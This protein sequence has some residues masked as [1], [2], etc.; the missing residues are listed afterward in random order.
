MKWTDRQIELAASM[1]GHYSDYSDLPKAIELISQTLGRRVSDDSLYKAFMRRDMLPLSKWFRG[2]S[3]EKSL[4]KEWAKFAEPNKHIGSELQS[5]LDEDGETNAVQKLLIL[6]DIHDPFSDTKAVDLAVKVGKKRGTDV[7]IQL[8]D[9]MDCLSVSPYRDGE[10]K[11]DLLDEIDSANRLLDKLDSIGAKRKILT[12]GNHCAR[13]KKYLYNNAP[14]VARMID[15]KKELRLAERGWEAID[16]G[17]HI[18]VGKVA[19]THCV[20]GYGA[21]AHSDAIRDMG[22]STVI[23]HSHRML[24]HFESTIC[25]SARVGASMGH[26]SRPECSGK[27]MHKAQRRFWQLGFGSG[28]MLPNGVTFLSPCPIVNYKTVVDGV[29]YEG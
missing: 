11:I 15:I 10:I 16:Y 13:V 18:A 22:H 25:E 24:F 19:Y 21:K 12:I 14:A 8:G 23:G 3:G 29:V 6:P 7:L 1:L 2:G 20:A 9:L 4:E 27:H 17:D 26:L 28:V 5:L